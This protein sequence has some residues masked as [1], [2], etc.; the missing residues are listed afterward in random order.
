[1]STSV[2]VHNVS[3]VVVNTSDV[4]GTKWTTLTVHGQGDIKLEITLFN[5]DNDVH[6]PFDNGEG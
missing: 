6:I 3:R 2:S 4:T 5:E 1:M